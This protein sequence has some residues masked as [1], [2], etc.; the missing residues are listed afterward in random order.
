MFHG[1][2]NIRNY[3]KIFIF[4]GILILILLNYFVVFPYLLV[5]SPEPLFY[6]DNNDL[7]NH[8]VT[9]EVFDSYNESI[10]KGTYELAPD[11]HIAQPKS[12]WLLLRWSMPWSKGKYI[13]FAEGEYEFKVIL[14]S[15]TTD[16]CRTLP[17]VWSSVVIDIDKT[18]NADSPMRIGVITV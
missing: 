4:L 12:L 8:E 9:V 5:G 3:R 11:E 1:G 6:I 7:Q 16:T 15:E 14:D 2:I 13:Y 18:N 10:F 17:H